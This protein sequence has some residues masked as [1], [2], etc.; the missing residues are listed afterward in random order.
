MLLHNIFNM[1]NIEICCERINEVAEANWMV[2]YVSNVGFKETVI[3]VC[4]E[5][6]DDT[7]LLVL[8]HQDALYLL[9]HKNEKLTAEFKGRKVSLNWVIG[10]IKAN[11]D[12]KNKKTCEPGK[13]FFGHYRPHG[14]YN[15]EA[16]DWRNWKK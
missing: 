16:G 12:E 1:E 5:N 8:R 2:A 14:P 4:P 13:Q 3:K 10:F 11:S 9:K 6:L 15:D 7:P